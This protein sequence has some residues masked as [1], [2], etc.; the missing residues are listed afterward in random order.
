MAASVASQSSRRRWAPAPGSRGE[1]VACFRGRRPVRVK[2]G[3]GGG[4]DDLIWTEQRENKGR[5][6]PAWCATRRGRARGG[7]FGGVPTRVRGVG[8]R[9]PMETADASGGKLIRIQNIKW[10]QINSNSSEI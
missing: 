10:V 6:V 9:Q 4:V 7:G 3:S 8:G 1:A 5:G 2:E